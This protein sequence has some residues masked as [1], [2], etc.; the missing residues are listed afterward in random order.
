MITQNDYEKILQIEGISDWKIRWN[1]G[2]GLCCYER[3]EIWMGD[4]LTDI[5]LF[6]HEVAHALCPKE[7]CGNCW[8]DI[9][10]RSKCFVSHNGG[11]N[12][13]WGDCFTKLVKKYM[14]LKGDVL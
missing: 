14:I 2:S 13:I 7:A 12:A 11:H 5:A 6:L 4:D 9:D 3:K 8:V 10:K 1:T